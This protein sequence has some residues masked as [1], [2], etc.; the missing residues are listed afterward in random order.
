[1]TAL[2]EEADGIWI[3]LQGKDRKEKLK[4]IKKSRKRKQRIQSKNENKNRA[5]IAYY[6]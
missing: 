6:V 1:M 2:F 5:E 3:N 4:K